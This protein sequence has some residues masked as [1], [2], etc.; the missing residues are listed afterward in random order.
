MNASTP[1]LVLTIDGNR[2][3]DIPGFYAEVNRSFMA[4]ENWQLGESLDALDDMLYGGH[5]ALNGAGAVRLRWL[6]MDKSAADLGLAET[7]RW[8]TDKLHHPERFNKDTIRRQLEA[9]EAGTGQTFFQIVMEIFAS[10]PEI[11]LVRG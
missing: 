3:D 2:F 8:L 9:L 10:H 11:A 7:R 5:G 6:A 1:D 4:A